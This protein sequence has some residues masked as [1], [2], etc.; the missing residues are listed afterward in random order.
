[1]RRIIALLGTVAAL[2]ALA[3]SATPT[4]AA[5]NFH[6]PAPTVGCQNGTCT[7]TGF[8]VSGL[9]NDP[10]YEQLV[11][12]STYTAT[13]VNPA[14]N[15]APGQ[16]PVAVTSTSPPVGPTSAH[17]GTFTFAPL[18][19]SPTAPN[20]ADY[21]AKQVGCPNNNWSVSAFTLT[22]QSATLQLI[23]NGQVLY[24]QP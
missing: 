3:L 9:G 19:Y 8:T 1:M 7:V 5:V 10:L 11:V 17:N 21:S 20:P 15:V 24:S 12:T 4:L 22:S 6:G 14:G 16:K 13:C 23:R 18:T 2:V